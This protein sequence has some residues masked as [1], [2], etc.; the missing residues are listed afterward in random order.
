MPLRLNADT[1][2]CFTCNRPDG[3]RLPPNDTRLP[4]TSMAINISMGTNN[5]VKFTQRQNFMQI[6]FLNGLLSGQ[7]YPCVRPFFRY[8][9]ALLVKVI[10]APISIST[11]SVFWQVVSSDSQWGYKKASRTSTLR[12]SI[13]EYMRCRRPL[14]ISDLEVHSA[15]MQRMAKHL[16]VKWF[17]FHRQKF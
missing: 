2:N 3:Y 5:F 4:I 8:L 17:G 1:G 9:R 12:A 15:L 14:Q 6:C 16:P 10:Y 7:D 13:F 11:S